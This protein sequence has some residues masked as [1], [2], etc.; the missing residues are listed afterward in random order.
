MLALERRVNEMA[1]TFE[2]FASGQKATDH[3]LAQIL[4][5]VDQLSLASNATTLQTP[6]LSLSASPAPPNTKP[7]LSNPTPTPELIVIVSKVVSEGRSRVGKKKGGADEN[8]CKEHI[9]NTFYRMLGIAASREI[10]PFF[11]D[12]YGEPDTLPSQ[13]VDPD[14]NYCRPYPHWKSPLT[15][16]VAWIPT[17]LLRFKSTIPKDRSDL[18]NALWNL[19]DEQIITLLNDGPFKPAQAVWRDMKKTDADIEA[20]QSSARRY[21]QVDWKVAL[22]TAHI[23]TIASLQGPQ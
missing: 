21:Q 3:T 23:K 7:Y 18:P 14:T 13:F 10:C 8:S 12:E 11:E 4:A 16:Q 20:M 1:D 17:F 9:R 6:G 22:R 2:Q 5:A 15:K 19:S